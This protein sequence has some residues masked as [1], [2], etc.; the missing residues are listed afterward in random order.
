MILITK[1]LYI[2]DDI[3]SIS[4]VRYRTFEIK[5]RKSKVISMEP[6]LFRIGI[7]MYI[8][9]NELIPENTNICKEH[10][11]SEKEILKKCNIGE[12]NK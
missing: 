11:Y 6:V 9:Y 4:N 7:D 12:K 10:N 1:D 3:C 5:L 2:K 8:Y